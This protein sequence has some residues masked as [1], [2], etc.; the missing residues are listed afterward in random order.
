MTGRTL[1]MLNVI[2][3]LTGEAGPRGST[4]RHAARA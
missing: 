1:K 3:E 4:A 2:G